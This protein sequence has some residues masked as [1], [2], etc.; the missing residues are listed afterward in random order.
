[1][2]VFLSLN[3]ALFSQPFIQEPVP[4][5]LGY[6]ADLIAAAF[7]DPTP[8]DDAAQVWDFSGVSGNAVGMAEVFP[9]PNSPLA[10]SF[11][12]AEWCLRN[13]DQLS[14]WAAVGGEFTIFGNA[15]AA[16]FVTIPFSDPL[17]QWAYPMEYGDAHVDT[18]MAETVLFAEPYG[19]VGQASFE[20]DAWGSLM[21]PGAASSL[22]VLRGHYDQVYT[23]SYAGDTATWSLEQYLFFAQDSVFPIFYQEFLTVTDNDGNLLLEA[24]DVAW[25]NNVLLEVPEGQSEQIGSPYPNPAVAGE[26]LSWDLPPGWSWKA[27]DAGGKV[28]CTGS[29]G[30]FGRTE[31][32]TG[33]WGAGMVILVPV[34]ED[35]SSAMV[36][37]VVLN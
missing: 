10:K 29:A 23:E 3:G 17:V 35:G 22:E 37:R 24:S 16:N 26:V 19:L 15:N 28:L 11:D 14:F 4:P 12:G 1:M 13:G 8:S 7:I 33:G 32:E 27:V 20:V 9:A 30:A 31:I 5:P 25:Y 21:M 2:L 18:F 34:R 36:R 6:T